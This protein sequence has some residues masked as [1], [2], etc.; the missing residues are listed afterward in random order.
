M[1]YVFW[2][3]E[4]IKNTK[5]Y[6]LGYILTDEAFNI[7]KQETIIDLSIDVSKRHSPKRKVNELKNSSVLFEN[8]YD[9]AD[10]I[11]SIIL[12]EET[13]GVCFG[14]EDYIALNDQL[15]IYQQ[16]IVQ[17][18][19]YDVKTMLSLVKELNLPTNLKSIA[20]KL[21]MKHDAHNP[22]SDSAVTMEI[23]RFLLKEKGVNFFTT[24]NIP[25]KNK[26]LD[27]TINKQ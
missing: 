4:R 22:L 15:K 9:F 24:S 8:F 19:F 1:K 7:I 18:T 20:E 3:T 23:F 14:T 11:K 12:Q 25:N 21:N 16:E 10:Y 27:I 26:V 17:G 2:D 6:L 5:I 13:I